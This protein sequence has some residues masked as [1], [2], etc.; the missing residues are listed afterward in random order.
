[1]PHR[2]SALYVSLTTFRTDYS[3]PATLLFSFNIVLFT[4]F[5]VNKI[6]VI[7]RKN[8]RKSWN[9][10]LGIVESNVMQILHIHTFD[11]WRYKNN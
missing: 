9:N 11:D 6:S 7:L 1:M 3:V 4:A 10:V 8:L 2:D 5:H